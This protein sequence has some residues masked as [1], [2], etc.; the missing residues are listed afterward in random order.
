MQP[1]IFVSHGAPN[2]VLVESEVRTALKGLAKVLEK[3]DAIIIASAH[4]ETGVSEVVSDPNP[5]TMYDFG[6]FDPRLYE[7]VYPAPG[8]PQL[9]QEVLAALKSS[10]LESR[11][12]PERDYDHGVWTPLD[13]G[14]SCGGYSRGPGFRSAAS[15]CSPPSCPRQGSLAGFGRAIS[16]SWAQVI[17]PTICVRFFPQCREG[18]LTRPQKAK[19][20]TFVEWIGDS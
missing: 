19:V 5:G 8:A 18:R 2:V 11:I 4:F 7:M 20:T 16:W 1:S 3:P 12:N 6:G 17:S 9:A 15:R 13:A 10:G 14:F